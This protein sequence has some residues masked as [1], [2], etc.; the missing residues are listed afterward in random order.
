MFVPSPGERIKSVKNG[1]FDP[2]SA[3]LE[4]PCTFK[5]S[6]AVPVVPVEPDV[7]NDKKTPGPEL[8][9]TRRLEVEE[10]REKKY[11]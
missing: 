11:K 6:L 3:V 4:V 8:H 10:P 5:G 2:T 7:E 9:H 1:S